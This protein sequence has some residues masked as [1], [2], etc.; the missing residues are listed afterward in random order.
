L[1]RGREIGLSDKRIWNASW[2]SDSVMLSLPK[3]GTSVIVEAVISRQV[4]FI[5]EKRRRGGVKA[6]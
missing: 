3:A 6:W 4:D 1:S 2:E 5:A